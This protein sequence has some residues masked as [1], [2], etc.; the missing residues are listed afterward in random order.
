MQVLR[1]RREHTDSSPFRLDHRM[2]LV[3]RTVNEHEAASGEVTLV[4]IQ[5]KQR[6]VVKGLIGLLVDVRMPILVVQ[7]LGRRISNAREECGI[8]E[9]DRVEIDLKSFA[10]CFG[11]SC[12]DVLINK[13]SKLILHFKSQ[14][15]KCLKLLD[16]RRNAPDG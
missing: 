12:L 15:L 13:S 14:I 8:R 1:A 10:D 6:R 11:D 3:L 2:R 16:K 5:V 7:R 4:S 9:M